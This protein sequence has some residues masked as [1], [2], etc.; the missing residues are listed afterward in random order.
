MN[1]E[2][3]NG[4]E[5]LEEDMRNWWWDKLYIRHMCVLFGQVDGTV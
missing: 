2:K 3:R 5:G 4:W 1:Y